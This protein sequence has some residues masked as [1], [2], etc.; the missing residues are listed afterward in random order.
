MTFTLQT[1]LKFVFKYFG[2][3]LNFLSHH[4]IAYLDHSLTHFFEKGA[5]RCENNF[6]SVE[7]ISS[8]LFRFDEN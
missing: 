4:W 2:G 8:N 7:R 1:F 3:A 5:D 6:L